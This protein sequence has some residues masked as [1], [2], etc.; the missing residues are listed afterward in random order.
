MESFDV[1]QIIDQLKIE[2]NSEDL[3]GRL[4]QWKSL[5]IRMDMNNQWDFKKFKKELNDELLIIQS[6][7]KQI[8]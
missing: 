4:N 2:H 6:I 3:Q 1:I 8:K 5:I 7:L